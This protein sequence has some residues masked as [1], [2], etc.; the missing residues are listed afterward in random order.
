[1]SIAGIP[2][3]IILKRGPWVIPDSYSAIILIVICLLGLTAQLLLAVSFKRLAASTA[4]ALTSSSIVWGV[5]FE[6]LQGGYPPPHG[7]AG[8]VLYL[9]GMTPLSMSGKSSKP[10]HGSRLARGAAESSSK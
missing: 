2:E 9:V 7:I 4:S 3:A 8:C 10:A 1:M 6:V 5:L